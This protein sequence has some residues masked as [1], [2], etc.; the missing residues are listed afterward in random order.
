MGGYR[1]SYECSSLRKCDMSILHIAALLLGICPA[2]TDGVDCEISPSHGKA[3]IQMRQAMNDAPMKSCLSFIHIPKNMGGT[4][5]IAGNIAFGVNPADSNDTCANWA[6]GNRTS[7][8]QRFWGYCDDH[9]NCSN[10]INISH[11]GVPAGTDA[12]VDQCHFQHFPPAWDPTLAESYVQ[13]D[14]FCILRHPVDRFISSFLWVHR[15][16]DDLSYCSPKALETY[17]VKH[18]KDLSV[19]RNRLNGCLLVPQVYYVFEKGDPQ[20]PQICRHVLHMDSID[21]EF[22]ALMKSY[23]LS[24]DLEGYWNHRSNDCHDFSPTRKTIKLVE[25]FYA[26]DYEAFGFSRDA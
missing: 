2:G 13:C 1:S 19:H 11:C 21:H 20:Q 15:N 14:T 23:G 4:V 5:E 12:P 8:N 17:A 22:P 24:V 16:E 9:L 26:Q 18:L 3:L 10:R 25:D 6:A 7:S